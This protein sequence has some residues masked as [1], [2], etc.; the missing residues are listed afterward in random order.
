MK[1]IPDGTLLI[2]DGVLGDAIVKEE[3]DAQEKLA[4]LKRSSVKTMEGN[5]IVVSNHNSRRGSKTLDVADSAHA[6]SCL[7]PRTASQHLMSMQQALADLNN[8]KTSGS[9]EY[10]GYFFLGGTLLIDWLE[11]RAD[12]LIDDNVL[13]LL[14]DSWCKSTQSRGVKSNDRARAISNADTVKTNYL[15]GQ[16]LS[17]PALSSTSAAEIEGASGGATQRLGIATVRSMKFSSPTKKANDSIN[18]S[19]SSKNSAGGVRNS[20]RSQRRMMSRGETYNSFGSD[21]EPVT[22]KV[23][24]ELLKKNMS[25]FICYTAAAHYSEMIRL[26]FVL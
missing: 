23:L 20:T 3:R 13:D 8:D 4:H 1:R 16:E 7:L 22:A 15:L 24:D 17:L 11:S 19:S 26:L 21:G 12:P 9:L 25:R 14:S 18:L 6:E 2:S 10:E 5:D